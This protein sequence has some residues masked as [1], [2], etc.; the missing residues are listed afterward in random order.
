MTTN[1]PTSKKTK[2]KFYNKFVYKISFRIK[3]SEILRYY[4]IDQILDNNILNDFK[5][6]T[7]GNLRFK[8]EIVKLAAENKQV[9]LDFL[10]LINSY[11]KKLIQLRIEGQ[12][13]DV[14]TN[15]DSLYEKLCKDFSENIVKRWEPPLGQKENILE[16]N[17]KIFVKHLPHLKYNYKVFLYPH[18]IKGDRKSVIQWFAKQTEK[19]TISD[20]IVAWMHK[21]TQN[22]D[23]RYIL[24][25][26]DQT[27]LMLRLRCP[28]LIGPVHQYVVKA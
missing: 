10:F 22:W 6:W 20:S 21:Q 7:R 3:G 16:S 11:D 28:E 27:I 13:L 4:S 18:K 17:R 2:Q 1:L 8:D 24:V 15:E 19:T 25:E 23:R 26:D 5:S 12:G 9:L 14:Y